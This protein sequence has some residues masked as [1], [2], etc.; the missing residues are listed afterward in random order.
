MDYEFHYQW[1]Q[2][3]D[4]ESDKVDP[5]G[6]KDDISDTGVEVEHEEKYLEPEEI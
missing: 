1:V 5:Y 2:V 3:F 6:E 4:N